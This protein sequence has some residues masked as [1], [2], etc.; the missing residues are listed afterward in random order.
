MELHVAAAL[1]HPQTCGSR[2]ESHAPWSPW[3]LNGGFL[4]KVSGSWKAQRN[5]CLF[6]RVWRGRT[7]KELSRQPR[8]AWMRPISVVNIPPTC[9]NPAGG[10]RATSRAV[11]TQLA[12]AQTMRAT[13]QRLRPRASI[14]IRSPSRLRGP[15]A[16]VRFTE[17]T[18]HPK[19]KERP[20]AVLAAPC[21]APKPHRPRAEAHPARR[22]L[23]IRSRDP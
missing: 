1:G 3:A 2:S 20:I 6:Y 8:T 13:A 14:S 7:N 21:R 9:R 23:R 16:A 22:R 5:L 11:G 17:S 18:G 10:P 4:V 19:T 12:P 15:C